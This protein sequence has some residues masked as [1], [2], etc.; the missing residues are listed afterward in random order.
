MF[1]QDTWRLRSNLTLTGG[2]RYDI[3]TPFAPFTSVMSSATMESVCGRSG[4]GDGGL[5][6]RCNFLSPGSLNG[7]APQ[8]IQ[9]EKGSEGYKIDWNN[10]AP[11]VSAAWRPN[12]ES[13]F[14]RKIMG[15]PDQATGA[16]WVFRGL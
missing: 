3:Q 7:V 4:L 1:A 9:F 5:Y 6:S 8:Y 11:S 10:I 16:R 12:V 15:D 2:I 14:L 13:G